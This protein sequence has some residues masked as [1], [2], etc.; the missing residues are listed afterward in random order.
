MTSPR[1]GDV[2]STSA[3]RTLVLT[4]S[5]ACRC[6]LPLYHRCWCRP[7]LHAEFQTVRHKSSLL[8]SISKVASKWSVH[9]LLKSLATS[10]FSLRPVGHLSL[11]LCSRCHL[12]VSILFKTLSSMPALSRARSR[13]AS[14][15]LILRSTKGAAVLA[16][17]SM[18]ST[19]RNESRRIFRT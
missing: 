15:F 4:T 18:C 1:P 10:V 19:P 8:L 11:C 7:Q 2:A 14:V 9:R 16:R 5:H 3:Y 12:V 13:K 6:L 17:P